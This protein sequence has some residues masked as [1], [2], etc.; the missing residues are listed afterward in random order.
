MKCPIATLAAIIFL[1]LTGHTSCLAL[2]GNPIRSFA[3]DVKIG[4][5]QRVAADP[6]FGAKSVTE[7]LLA[8]G[9]QFTAE[10][11]RRGSQLLPEFDFVLAGVLTAVVGKYY[12][13]WRVAPTA[14][15]RQ[16]RD[17]VAEP[18]LFGMNVPTNAFQR[19]M[20]DG[21]TIPSLQ[22]RVASFLV[23]VMPLFR[24]G[25]LASCAGYGLT[26]V[27]I[28]LRSWLVPSFVQQTQNVNILHA[29]LYTGAFM[30]VVSNVRYQLL[31][32]LIEPVIDRG[33][34]GIPI[35]RAAF[36]FAIRTANGL[37]GSALAISG[38]RWLGLQRRK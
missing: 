1:Q 20:M 36:I 22:Q 3:N 2:Q 11:E 13:M 10:W 19:T 15:G 18:T 24:A 34:S 17:V 37:L 27:M 12:S 32:G 35:L 33:L 16:S 4:Y 14:K 21:V 28:L 25:F 6:S 30:A 29:S 8:A 7:I 9:T 26:A 5:R 23:P 31:Q 38:M